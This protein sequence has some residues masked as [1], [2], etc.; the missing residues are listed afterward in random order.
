MSFSSTLAGRRSPPSHIVWRC[1]SPRVFVPCS[2]SASSHLP[3]G[4]VSG[5]RRPALA[6]CQLRTATPAARRLLLTLRVSL[7]LGR[8]FCGVPP[9]KL[10]GRALANWD[11]ARAEF[12]TIEVSSTSG[13]LQQWTAA[14]ASSIWLLG[15]SEFAP[16]YLTQCVIAPSPNISGS[17]SRA[18]THFAAT[19][20]ILSRSTST[21]YNRPE[22]SN[23]AGLAVS[24][25]S[26]PTNSATA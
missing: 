13:R 7:A 21:P 5:T 25:A 9:S 2:P 11:Q 22:H 1:A 12:R 17:A 20:L 8:G 24:K 26:L 14:L 3:Y 10:S 4:L 15:Q 6:V 18:T 23:L 16:P 19:K